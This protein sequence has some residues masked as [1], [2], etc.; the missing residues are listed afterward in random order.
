MSTKTTFKRIALVTVAALGFGALSSVSPARADGLQELATSIAVGTSQPA[1]SGVYSTTP[2][3]LNLASTTAVGDTIVLAVKLL[4]APATSTYASV[5]ANPTQSAYT[6]VTNNSTPH[7]DITKPATG[8]GSFG[9]I[10]KETYSTS[11]NA[12]ATVQYALATGDSIGQVV[13]NVNFKPDVSGTYTFLVSTPN[14]VSDVTGTPADGGRYYT[15]TSDDISTTF[16]ITTAN[17]AASA[18]LAAVTAAASS[19]SGVVGQVMKLNLKDSAGAATLLSSTDS[20]ALSTSS[21]TVGFATVTSSSA[22][23]TNT[24]VVTRDSTGWS[25]DTFY[26]RVDNS[27]TT[28]ESVTITATGNGTLSSSLVYSV[29][30]SFTAATATP[31]AVTVGLT[32]T[33]TSLVAAGASSC[34]GTATATS[35]PNCCL[36]SSCRYLC[37]G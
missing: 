37:S 6:G 30:T 28:S 5:S 22:S 21:T 4:T 23:T 27:S 26:F 11:G 18:T 35:K 33:E 24:M 16:S 36:L 20:I 15:A 9:T 7:L 2:V 13:L 32:S 14:A 17:A 1:R 34:S 31:Q 8:S 29:G 25:G 12:T 19:G 10:D 3:T